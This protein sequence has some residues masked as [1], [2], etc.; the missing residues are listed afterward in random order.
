MTTEDWGFDETWK[1]EIS[2]TQRQVLIDALQRI[3][4]QER[5][6]ADASDLCDHLLRLPEYRRKNPN[7]NGYGLCA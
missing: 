3:S 7:A 4:R 2:E 5:N 1:I 6:S